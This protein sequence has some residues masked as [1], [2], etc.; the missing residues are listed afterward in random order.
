[1]PEAISGLKQIKINGTQIVQKRGEGTRNKPE[2][3]LRGRLVEAQLPLHPPPPNPD[4]HY[5]HCL[6]EIKTLLSWNNRYIDKIIMDCLITT[7]L[8]LKTD[9]NCKWICSLTSISLL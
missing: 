4:K 2:E 3:S 5:S 7:I 1:M 8:S 6:S 9:E